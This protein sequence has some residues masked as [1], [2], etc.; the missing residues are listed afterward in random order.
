MT[1][2]NGLYNVKCLAVTKC[3]VD[4][5]VKRV[6]DDGKHQKQGEIHSIYLF[7]FGRFMLFHASMNHNFIIFIVSGGITVS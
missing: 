7:I 6:C 1:I 2:E 5:D 3:S 4:P